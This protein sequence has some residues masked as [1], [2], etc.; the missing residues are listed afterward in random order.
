MN[1]RSPPFLFPRALLYLQELAEELTSAYQAPPCN[2]TPK[3]TPR[4]EEPSRKRRGRKP[5]EQKLEDVD[6]VPSEESFLQEEEEEEHYDLV[7]NEA[8]K[9][10]RESSSCKPV[11]TQTWDG[12]I[13]FLGGLNTSPGGMLEG[14]PPEEKALVFWNQLA[15]ILVAR[16]WE[17]GLW[18]LCFWLPFFS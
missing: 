6:F 14:T 1:L 18:G 4:T 10:E 12:F 5:K 2:E 17:G 9:S 16:I 8:M 13:V 3:D 11:V 7:M 15:E